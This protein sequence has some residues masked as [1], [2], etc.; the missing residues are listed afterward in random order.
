[1]A[2]VEI[3]PDALQ[4]IERA[5]AWWRD[6]RAAAPELLT[7]ELSAAFELLEEQ[8]DVGRQL[9]RVRFPRLRVLLMPRTR[10]TCTTSTIPTPT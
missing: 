9:P 1:M 4:Q 6:H 2:R 3:L 10:Y 7:V 5:A 8:P